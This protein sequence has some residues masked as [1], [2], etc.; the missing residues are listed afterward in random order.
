M[1]HE[2]IRLAVRRELLREHGPGGDT[3]YK[4]E[5]GIGLGQTRVDVAAIN[6]RL[7]GYEIKSDRDSLN[8]LEHQVPLYNKVLDVA[9][10]VTEKRFAD[11]AADVVPPWWGIWK[12]VP[13]GRWPVIEQVRSRG[14]NPHL[15][16]FSIAQLLWRDEA[17]AILVN[18][19]LA[20]GLRSAT[21]WRLWE[22]LA[23]ELTITVLA[24]AVRSQL[25]ARR[26]W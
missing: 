16:P 11:K 24:D 6:G 20:A 18:L 9:V 26:G 15:D 8:R 14:M 2:E 17:Y 21:R 23:T 25:R 13:A 7:S 12:C 3:R 10:L 19:E 4:Y 1:R 5:F 22:T